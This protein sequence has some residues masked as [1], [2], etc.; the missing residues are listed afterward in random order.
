MV[1]IVTST[2][3]SQL[4]ELSEA[5]WYIYIAYEVPV[6]RVEETEHV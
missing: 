4:S 3:V 1:V 2:D 6:T 5:T